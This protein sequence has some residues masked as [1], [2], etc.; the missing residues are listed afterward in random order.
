MQISNNIPNNVTREVSLSL[1]QGRG[2]AIGFNDFWFRLIGIPLIGAFVPLV[3]FNRNFGDEVYWISFVISMLYTSTYWFLCRRVFIVANTKFP[4]FKQNNK[5]LKFILIY[6]G[7]IILLLCPLVHEVI[8]PL[9]GHNLSV[10]PFSFRPTMFQIYAANITMHTAI[11][12]I[13]ESIR[14]FSL[15]E[16]TEMEKELLEKEHLNSQLE[17]LKSQ[18]NPHFL[19]NS[20]NTLVHL[21]P[22]DTQRSVNFVQQMAKVY[23]YFL[24]TVSEKTVPLKQEM[25][26][27]KSYTFL[28]KERFGENLHITIDDKNACSDCQIVPFSLQ[29]LLENCIKHNVISKDKPLNINILINQKALTVKNNIQPKNQNQE[30]T[31]VGLKNIENRYA[32][33]STE[34][35]VVT[36]TVDFFEVILPLL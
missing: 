25:D 1:G 23:R 7:L 29:L 10:F 13:Y 31:G 17:G 36:K 21:I 26:F 19:F 9:L 16:T 6:C 14:N 30:S 12:T 8:E 11:A 18:V 15:W 24:D 22:E 28:L 33:L 5:R 4:S 34:K 20:L 32:L 2:G 27:V 3:F 35:V